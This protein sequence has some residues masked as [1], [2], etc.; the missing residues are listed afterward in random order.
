MRFGIFVNKTTEDLGMKNIIITSA[1]ALFCVN[2]NAAFYLKTNEGN[3]ITI[4]KNVG[5]A[6]YINQRGVPDRYIK[7][8]TIND[9]IDD[10]GRPYNSITFINE[11]CKEVSNCKLPILGLKSFSDK[12]GGANILFFDQ[13]GNLIKTEYVSEK[14]MAMD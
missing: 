14:D 8:F 2:A 12:E 4:S 5:M 1:L 10:Q 3:K 7:D 13:K 9:K 11:K 6:V